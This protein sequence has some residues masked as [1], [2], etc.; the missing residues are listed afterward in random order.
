MVLASCAGMGASGCR[1]EGPY[2]ARI[3]GASPALEPASPWL[4][5]QRQRAAAAIP[6]DR[7]YGALVA[8]FLVQGYGV[9]PIERSLMARLLADRLWL[10]GVRVADPELAEVAL[11]E[12]G[13]DD[14]G[15]SPHGL[16][17]ARE[18]ADSLA[19]Q[20]LV[21]GY[22][23]HR[24]DG[25]LR[26]TVETYERGAGGRLPERPT[27]VWDR[28][29]LLL[30]H[31]RLPSVVL[32]DELD[33]VASSVLGRAAR[34]RGALLGAP[35]ETGEPPPLSGA[36]DSL[37]ADSMAGPLR[38]AHLLQFL[39]RLFPE[40]RE[41][42]RLYERSLVALWRT[43][44]E[45]PHRALLEARAWH[46][47]QRRPA[48]R[49]V[50]ATATAGPAEAALLGAL[51]GDLER[52]SRVDAIGPPLLRLLARAERFD[53]ELAYGRPPAE[54]GE[55]FA[56]LGA[57][58]GW[59]WSPLWLRSLAGRFEHPSSAREDLELLESL[60]GAAD[61]G[62]MQGIALAKSWG[63][64]IEL[65]MAP[66]SLADRALGLGIAPWVERA[67]LFAPHPA[68]LLRLIAS[69]G[70]AAAVADVARELVEAGSSEQALARVELY[71]PVYAGHPRLE[72]LRAAALAAMAERAASPA[73]AEE[74]GREAFRAAGRALVWSGG[75]LA[76]PGAEAHP[77][78]GL[79]SAEFPVHAGWRLPERI[80]PLVGLG[81]PPPLDWIREVSLRADYS[82]T[83]PSWLAALHDRL[84]REGA[85]EALLRLAL[86]NERRFAGHPQRPAF[87]TE[88]AGAEL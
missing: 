43:P 85:T 84:A 80:P 60:A 70:D 7:G 1:V 2:S 33:S 28:A 32:R 88:G 21:V 41:R 83:D 37:V 55:T 44:L 10:A 42:E 6:R 67:E 69:R 25:K 40:G 51:D 57:E 82:A 66:R 86:D 46:H 35:V 29:E 79:F 31:E 48:A 38:A 50:L 49:A 58:V 20:Y 62:L 68:D 18:L 63:D 73:R 72:A 47:L 65:F 16:S 11:G 75:T 14:D 39:A 13:R 36:F 5:S 77:L 27:R 56:V 52:A 19:A 81:A 24:F 78:F 61:P 17:S 87:L 59:W 34:R 9:D 4:E 15:V 26:I 22:A 23:G 45:T 8:P 30:S 74:L 76:P 71:A 54:L 53:L 12:T 3:A 64:E